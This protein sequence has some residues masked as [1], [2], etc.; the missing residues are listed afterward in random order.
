LI[1]LCYGIEKRRFTLSS[2]LLTIASLQSSHQKHR[3]C[4]GRSVS[5]GRCLQLLRTGFLFSVGVN[6]SPLSSL[7]IFFLSLSF[8]ISLYLSHFSLSLSLT[9]SFSLSF[10][11]FLSLYLSH[12]LTLSFFLSFYFCLSLAFSISLFQFM[13]LCLTLSLSLSLSSFLFLS[14]S[15]SPFHF[16]F[17]THG[18]VFLSRILQRPTFHFHDNSIESSSRVAELRC[19]YL[20]LLNASSS[21]F[22]DRRK[23]YVAAGPSE[24]LGLKDGPLTI[25]PKWKTRMLGK[26]SVRLLLL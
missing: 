25:S 15:S 13:S 23:A 17:L 14:L 11:F 10:S 18:A 4:S 26:L 21:S 22:M 5:K 12:F 1:F 9:L 6:F 16:I 2:I 7:F 24:R 3:L 20:G 19:T 8:F